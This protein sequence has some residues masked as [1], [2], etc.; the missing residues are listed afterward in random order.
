MHE[1][2]ALA[3]RRAEPVGE[4]HRRRPGAALGPVDHDEVEFDTG[5]EHGLGNGHEFPAV[6]EAELEADRLATRKLSQGSD[7]FQ[8]FQRSGKGRMPGW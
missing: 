6:A 8:Q 7:E 3:E 5:S 1:G 2:K 4:F